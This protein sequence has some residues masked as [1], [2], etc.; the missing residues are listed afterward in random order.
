MNSVYTFFLAGRYYHQGP[1]VVDG[2]LLQLER[3]PNNIHDSNAIRVTLLG[4][5]D[6][7]IGFVPRRIA[8]VLAPYIDSGLY[9]ADMVVA[10]RRPNCDDI[11]IAFFLQHLP[12]AHA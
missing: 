3:D 6:Q 2:T 7:Q 10:R 9:T 11:R 4:Q 8:M 1:T 5:P 12:V